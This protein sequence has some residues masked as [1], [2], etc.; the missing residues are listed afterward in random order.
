MRATSPRGPAARQPIRDWH[1]DI[2]LLGMLNEGW[3]DPD[4]LGA[5]YCVPP[6][7]SFIEHVTGCSMDRP[8]RIA[9]HWGCSWMQDGTR[10][11]SK[12]EKHRWLCGFTKKGQ[13]EFLGDSPVILPDDHWGLRW[14][15]EAPP[16]Y[17]PSAAAS[18][19]SPEARASVSSAPTRLED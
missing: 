9:G 19:E 5:C 3:Q 12:D 18:E 6:V 16:G 11:R 15:T 4:Q 7:G 1:F 14:L 2:V 13:P 8:G 10:R 17:D